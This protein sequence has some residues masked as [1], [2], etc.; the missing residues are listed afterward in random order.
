MQPEAY[1]G[2]VVS[3]QRDILKYIAIKGWLAVGSIQ[4]VLRFEL[5]SEAMVEK[6]DV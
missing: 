1:C 2:N 3:K 6:L 4:T 5:S